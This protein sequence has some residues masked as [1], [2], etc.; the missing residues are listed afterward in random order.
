MSAR[1]FLAIFLDSVWLLAIA[2]ATLVGFGVLGPSHRTLQLDGQRYELQ[3]SDTK[4]QQAKGL[5]G[6]ASLPT[7][8]GML[9]VFDQSVSHCFWMKD[10]HFAI[11][12]IWLD[13]RKQVTH[14][15]RRITPDTYPHTFCPTQP[16]RYVIELNAGQAD[17]HH[18]HK[19]QQLSF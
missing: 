11:D 17:A 10:M 13:D 6:R 15:E 1:K 9:F 5:G 19:G 3:V 7:D 16:S 18:V 2:V 8:K 12:I 14:I 4:S